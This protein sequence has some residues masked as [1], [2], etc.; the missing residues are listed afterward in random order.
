MDVTAEQVAEALETSICTLLVKRLRKVAG[1]VFGQE[2]DAVAD[3]ADVEEWCEKARDLLAHATWK[4]CQ[5]DVKAARKA[6]AK[7]GASASVLSA[8][9][10]ANAEAAKKSISKAFAGVGGKSVYLVTASGG[11]EEIT[12]AWR[13]MQ[14]AAAMEPASTAEQWMAAYA[15]LLASQGVGIVTGNSGVREI[16]GEVRRAALEAQ[17]T[18][19][20]DVNRAMALSVGMDAVQI[21]AHSCCAAD[22][23]PYQGKVYTLAELEVLNGALERPI[24]RGVMN[25]RHE[26]LYCYSGTPST[27]ST[28]DLALLK[29]E[30]E[31]L[32]SYTGLSG[33][34]LTGTRYESTQ[35]MRRVERTIRKAKR[36]S[37][38]RKAAGLDVSRQEASVSKLTAAY[39]ALCEELGE[40]FT[41]SRI[42][43]Y[44]MAQLL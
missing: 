21:S 6:M 10:T 12:S 33:K 5:R 30:S 19:A 28:S 34:T 1:S 27:Y 26:L 18:A 36:Q 16:A 42:A 39:E 15:D 9:A 8:T 2:L 38:V 24:G 7:M 23:L 44:T 17:M 35:Y 25:C 31:R 40:T 13:S 11:M 29:T 20:D 41:D 22:H 3:L 32:V 14:L 37:A 43:A 4:E